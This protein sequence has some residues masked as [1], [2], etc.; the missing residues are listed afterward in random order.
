MKTMFTAL[1][2]MMFASSAFAELPPYYQSAAEMKAVLESEGVAD[3]LGAGG[4]IQSI[5]KVYASASAPAG[6]LVASRNC[7]VFVAIVYLPMPEGLVGPA[8]FRLNVYKP[9][10]S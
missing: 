9:R 8:Q 2:V 10:C 7:S 5:K 6:Y 1:A 4:A 3:A